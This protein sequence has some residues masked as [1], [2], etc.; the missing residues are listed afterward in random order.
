MRVAQGWTGQMPM[1]EVFA[2]MKT[3]YKPVV[4]ENQDRLYESS[5]SGRCDAMTQDFSALAA[6]VTTQTKTPEDFV[7]L[8]ERVSKEP[9]GPFV[10]HGD[11]QWFDIVK[12]AFM[13]T[14]EAEEKGITQA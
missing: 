8:P 2:T 6:V 10:R 1:G 12:Y 13:A 4:L 9:L 14:I 11:D 5:L 7:I 3:K